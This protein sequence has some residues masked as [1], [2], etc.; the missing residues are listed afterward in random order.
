MNEVIK[1]MMERR[2]I[3]RYKLEQITDDELNA[4]LQAGMYA[5][6]AGGRQGVVFLVTQNKEINE[7]LGKINKSFFNGR[8]FDKSVYIS[9]SQP[10]I[11]DDPGITSGFYGAPTVITIFGAKNWL[12]CESDCSVAAENIMLA[13]HSLSLG[14]CMIGRAQETFETEYGKEL[15][16]KHGDLDRYMPTYHVLIGY[17]ICSYKPTES[18]CTHQ[19]FI[20]GGKTCK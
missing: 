18:P 7:R 16:K 2:A 3:R 14:S 11:A 8:I 4:V 15:L 1:C 17:H 10:S 6:S 20:N 9:E 12:Y 13:A 19:Q 5:P